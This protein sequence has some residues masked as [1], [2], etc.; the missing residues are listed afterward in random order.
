M[1]MRSCMPTII[2]S[3]FPLMF[4]RYWRKNSFL[5]VAWSFHAALF[6]SNLHVLNDG[7]PNRFLHDLRL[8]F[9]NQ[10]ATFSTR[11][12][13]YNALICLEKTNVVLM[14]TSEDDMRPFSTHFSNLWGKSLM[15]LL[16]NRDEYCLRLQ[17]HFILSSSL[18]SSTTDVYW[19]NNIVVGLL[20]ADWHSL[21]PSEFYHFREKW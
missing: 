1:I 4:A 7:V 8:R 10:F 13:R 9:Q 14:P 18:R 17:T 20:Q 11:Q 21:G 2:P 15:Q 19:Q 5:L 12:K 16:I 3:P 6:F